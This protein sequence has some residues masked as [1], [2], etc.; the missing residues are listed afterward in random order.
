MPLRARTMGYLFAEALDSIRKNGV[1]SFA[2]VSTVALTLFVLA[3]FAVIALNV[4]H[5]TSILESQVQVVAYLKEDFD[6]ARKDDVV[7]TVR[8]LDGVA[9]V[10]YVTK[11]EALERLRKQFGEQADLL[12]A[13]AEDNPLVDSL[14]VRLDSP[15][16]AEGVVAKLQAVDGVDKVGYRRDTVR[17]LHSVATALRALGT[18]L[19]GLLAFATV[20]IV[21][22]TIRISVF[23]RR[24]EIGIMKLVGATD[25]F[26]RWPFLMEGAVLGLAGALLAAV[27]VS[28]GYA[29]LV[30]KVNS[31]LPFIPVIPPMPF[32]FDISKG[33]LLAGTFLGAMGSL[34]SL[35]RHLKV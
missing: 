20:L 16:V 33:L 10:R 22:N 1:M 30:E 19:A 17:R 13:V 14:E 29:W 23:A 32:L 2:S 11:E 21:S 24:R 7:R 12:D 3:V 15:A 34:L 4:Q 31:I 25:W 9:D 18:A 8:F 35:R 28:A 26:I 6:R 27:A 5:M